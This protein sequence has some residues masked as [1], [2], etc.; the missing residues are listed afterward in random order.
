VRLDKFVVIYVHDVGSAARTGMVPLLAVSCAAILTAFAPAAP[1]VGAAGR[2][3]QTSAA[4]GTQLW[5]SQYNGPGNGNDAASS[6]A[7]SP[8]GST[9]YVTGRSAGTSN[10]IAVATVAY[11][12]ATGR[13]LW[14]SRYDAPGGDD[15]ADALAVSPD[16]KT[17]FVTGFAMAASNADYLTIAY[18]AATGARQ[19]VR[20]YNGPGNGVDEATSIAVNPGGGTVYV[21]GNSEGITSGPDYATIAYDAATGARRWIGRYNGPGNGIDSASAVAVSPDGHTV[22]VTGTSKGA[23]SGPDYATVAYDAATGHRHWVGRYNGPGNNKDDAR[24]L[25][26]S[27]DSRT[28]FVTGGS[29]GTSSGFDYTT[30]AYR[31]ATGARLW[32]SRYRGPVSGQDVAHSVAVGPSGHTVFVTGYAAVPSGSVIATVAYNAASGAR[33]WVKQFQGGPQCNDSGS[34]VAVGPGGGL[35]FVTGY[36]T[37][38]SCGSGSATIAYSTATGAQVWASQGGRVTAANSIAVSPDGG[39]VF[40]T[41]SIFPVAGPPLDM[42]D[43]VTIAYQA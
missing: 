2:T 15:Q 5:L 28:V 43:Y 11:D 9:I 25:T 39:T 26:V 6:V 34:A 1:A 33:L 23:T 24:S 16:G 21:T 32:L 30:V 36:N 41:G 18:N 7:V 38:G 17:L 27:P 31:A 35:V 37:Q 8:D 13:Q 19:W 12:A 40:I 14:A 4:Q 29:F 42:L 10:S 22:F 3:G 20:R